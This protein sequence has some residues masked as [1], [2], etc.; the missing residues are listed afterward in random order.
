M[1]KTISKKMTL[2][3]ETIVALSEDH[4]KAAQGGLEAAA[5]QAAAWTGNSKDVCCC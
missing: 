4:A 5:E 2:S 3:R 1:K